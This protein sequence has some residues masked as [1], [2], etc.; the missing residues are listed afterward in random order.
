MTDEPTTAPV[1]V[2]EDTLSPDLLAQLR[3]D[4]EAQL[5]AL[6]QESNKTIAELNQSI[7]SLKQENETLR[8]AMVRTASMPPVDTPKE[9]TPEEVYNDLVNRCVNRTKELII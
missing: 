9:P 7:G 2:P 5:E 4:F 8:S 1:E 6:K 3:K